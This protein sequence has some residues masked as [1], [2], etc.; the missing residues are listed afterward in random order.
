MKRFYFSGDDDGGEEDEADS[1][2]FPMPSPSEFIA[3]GHIDSPFRHLLDCAIRMCER[4]LVWRFLAPEE[5]VKNVRMVFKS[6]AQIEREYE[7]D[8]EIRDEM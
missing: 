4:T 7:G 8:A 2:A 6:L 3:M 5:K 1:E